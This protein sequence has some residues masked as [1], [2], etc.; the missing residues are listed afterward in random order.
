M[1]VSMEYAVDRVIACPVYDHVPEPGG[2]TAL[3][4][5]INPITPATYAAP[6]TNTIR[7]PACYH[8]PF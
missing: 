5:H 4:A 1:L 3:L 8:G 6:T 7:Q 2:V